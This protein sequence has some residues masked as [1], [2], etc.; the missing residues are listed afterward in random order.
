MVEK[1]I[2]ALLLKHTKS[3]YSQLLKQGLYTKNC[4]IFKLQ[5]LC[6]NITPK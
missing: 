6:L 4:Q 3:R 2:R 5:I 1:K